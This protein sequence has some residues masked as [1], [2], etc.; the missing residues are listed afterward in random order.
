M[1]EVGIGV[2]FAVWSLMALASVGGMI[3]AVAALISVGRTD[4]NAFGP[5]WDN[6]KNAWL[7]GLAVSFAIPMGTLI[8]GVYWFWKGRPPIATT[9]QALRPFWIGPPKPAPYPTYGYPQGPYQP[10]GY[11]QGPTP[12]T[13]PPPATPAP[14]APEAPQGPVT[15]PGGPHGPA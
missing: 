14:P 9:G 10:C 2:F 6:T 13:A 8:G 5:W 4:A 7:L 12:W 3:C 11:P 1:V 15:H